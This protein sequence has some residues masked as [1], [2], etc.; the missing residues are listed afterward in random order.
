MYMTTKTKNYNLKG[1]FWTVY[2]S[3][4]FILLWTQIIKFILPK[5]TYD[6]N[7]IVQPNFRKVTN[8]TLKLKG[9]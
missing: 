3:Q 9:V 8:L 7:I 5:N 6:F 2:E 1:V 4:K